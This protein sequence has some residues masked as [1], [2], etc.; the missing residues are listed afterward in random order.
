[1]MNGQDCSAAAK[2]LLNHPTATCWYDQGTYHVGILHRDAVGNI[3]SV[4]V[5]GIGGSWGTALDDA[6]REITV[7][8]TV[9][10]ITGKEKYLGVL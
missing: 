1:M 10:A 8:Q 6:R 5:C 9:M 4:Q 7:K 2:A 3:L